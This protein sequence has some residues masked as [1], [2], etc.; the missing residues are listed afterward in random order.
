MKIKI[1]RSIKDIEFDTEMGQLN[2][3]ILLVTGLSGSGKSWLA[4]ELGG[5]YNAEI[6]QPEWLIHTKHAEGEGKVMLEN[7]LCEH[8]EI[9]SFAENKWNNCKVEDENELLKKYL[10]LFFNYFLEKRD[11]EKFY[12]VEGLQIFTL[13]DFNLLK[14][15]P[16]IIKGTSSFDSL[17]NRIKRDMGKRKSLNF[18][19]KTKYF[20][21]ILK[22][23]RLYQ[24][25][26]RKK[27]NIFIKKRADLK[28]ESI[29]K[30]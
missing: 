3:N 1:F 4:K 11:K 16:L 14:G 7:F 19:K 26:H 18:F 28:L 23:S 8:K 22:Q 25:K 27:L 24:F 21:K 13:I 15:F 30:Q 12:I 6:F 29:C 20:F 5:R 2:G 10:N 9:R 17:R